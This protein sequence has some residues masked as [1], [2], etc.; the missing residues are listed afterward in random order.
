MNLKKKIY[1][2]ANFTTQRCPK[3]IIKKNLFLKFFFHLPE[4][5]TTPVVHLEL[6]FEK[7]RNG[8]AGILWVWGETDSR[9]KPEAKNLV[10]LSLKVSF[11]V[12][13]GVS[14]DLLPLIV[15]KV[16]YCFAKLY[17]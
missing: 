17:S 1:L 7:I 16:C 8:L 11:S 3:E 5:S 2:Y 6:R 15:N 4:E 13:F 14:E 12:F 9:K 10:T